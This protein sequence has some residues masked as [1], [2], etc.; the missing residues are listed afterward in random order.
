MHFVPIR[1]TPAS[2][3]CVER[4]ACPKF[5]RKPTQ[6]RAALPVRR[7]LSH[8]TVQP[9]SPLTPMFRPPWPQPT[10]PTCR[11]KALHVGVRLLS[12]HTKVPTK[13]NCVVGAAWTGEGPVIIQIGV[14]ARGADGLLA[15]GV[16]R[17]AHAVLGVPVNHTC[18]L[19]ADLQPVA[20]LQ[21]L[22]P[23]SARALS[24]KGSL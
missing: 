16:W 8:H 15:L 10:K 7:L 9:A 11:H 23:G 3:R 6:S 5:N 22:A 18:A 1:L 4:C 17:R 24:T 2:S 12:L 14:C 20:V 19:A 21:L 13:C